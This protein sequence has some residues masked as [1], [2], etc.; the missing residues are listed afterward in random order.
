LD[1][2][3]RD[4]CVLLGAMAGPAHALEFDGT[5]AGEHETRPLGRKGPRGGLADPGGG[6]GDPDG[7]A[8]KSHAGRSSAEAVAS[9]PEM[10]PASGEIWS[11]TLITL[12]NRLVEW[13]GWLSEPASSELAVRYER[14]RLREPAPPRKSMTDRGCVGLAAAP[15]PFPRAVLR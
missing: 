11:D 9:R 3:E 10:R 8:G 7:L 13:W 5:T 6:A 15:P 14:G 12:A 1:E 4:D 2:V